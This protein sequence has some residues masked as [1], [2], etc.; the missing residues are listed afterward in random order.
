MT[1]RRN[2]SIN[3]RFHAG[4]RKINM[5][6]IASPNSVRMGSAMINRQ[7]FPAGGNVFPLFFW[8]PDGGQKN[9]L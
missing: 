2:Q 7:Y 4:E 6:V 8:P 9:K 5:A 1:G 3:Y